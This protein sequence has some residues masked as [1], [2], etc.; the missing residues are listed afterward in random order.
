MQ[1]LAAYQRGEE[2]L[3]YAA[4]RAGVSLREMIAAAR[5][6]G[7]VPRVDTSAHMLDSAA[8]L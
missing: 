6:R 5:S 8:Q 2:T 3:A 1:A 4:E 7:I